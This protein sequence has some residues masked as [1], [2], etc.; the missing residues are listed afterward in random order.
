MLEQLTS[1]QYAVNEFVSNSNISNYTLF[2]EQLFTVNINFGLAGHEFGRDYWMT[3]NTG[4]IALFLPLLIFKLNKNDLP[5]YS[6][7]LICTLL[8]YFCLIA[9]LNIFP[10]SALNSL[11][12]FHAISFGD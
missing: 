4:L 1:G 5:N 11:L 3:T 6:F 8:G 10:W 9:C 12:R 7:L 2:F